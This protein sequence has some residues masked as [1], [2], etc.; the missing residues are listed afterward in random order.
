MIS[1]TTIVNNHTSLLTSS[2]IVICDYL[3]NNITEIPNMTLQQVA[4]MTYSSKSNILRL[5][6]KLNF[7]GFTDFKYYLLAQNNHD[8]DANNFSNL[9]TT[10]E[11]IDFDLVASKFSHIVKKSNH[12]YLFATV[13]DQQIQA[14][15]L[16]N[17]LLKLGIITTFIPLNTNADLTS[18]II[19]SLQK[20]DLIIIFSSKGNN[21]VLRT[22]FHSIKESNCHLITFTT[23]KDGWIQVQ[24]ELAISLGITQFQNPILNYQSGLMHLLLNILSSKL[25]L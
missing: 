20:K 15:N 8:T 19:Q 24:A 2:D 5:L 18:N 4:E 16:G 9:I 11:N 17:Y 7:N 25:T 13:Q 22:N 3:T 6:K 21:D 12:I 1:F 14:K 10:L 23:F